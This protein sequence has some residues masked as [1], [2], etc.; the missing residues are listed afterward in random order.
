[1]TDDLLYFPYINMPQTNW[2]TIS[3]LYWDSI[4]AIVPDLYKDRP[5][6]LEHNMRELVENEL[7]RQV[8]PYEYVHQIPNFDQAFINLTDG[9]DFNLRIRQDAFARG[10]T[11]LLHVQK[12]S[13]RLLRE[14]EDKRL[15]RRNTWEW[16][17]VEQHTARMF[18]TY[19][20]TV[21]S[22]VEG[23]TPA[24]DNT[25]NMDMQPTINRFPYYRLSTRNKFI[26]DLIP[27]PIVASSLQL[28]RFKDLHGEQ[29]K[30]FRNRLEQILVEVTA[31]QDKEPRQHL[32][33][34]KL[35]EITQHRDEIYARLT[36]S[37]F[38]KIT[39]GTIFGL[40]AAGVGLHTGNPLLGSFGFGNAVHSA[41][42]GYDRREILNEDFAYLALIDRKFKDIRYFNRIA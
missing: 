10:H 31:I 29:L 6:K 21:I 41:F 18:M 8:F 35:Q 11:S 27:Y 38:G 7:V 25:R 16:Y 9:P 13:D 34:L 28:R 19:L 22:K 36:E 15:A 14:L 23:L 40:I 26:N 4:G 1:M 3:V 5:N 37:R 12:F 32:Y 20:A 33:N 2:T 30:A 17:L 42:Q 24:T 39:F